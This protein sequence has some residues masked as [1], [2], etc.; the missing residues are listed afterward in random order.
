MKKVIITLI[1]TFSLLSLYSQNATI[2]G[3]VED[4]KTGERLIGANVFDAS[5]TK[6]G[7]ATNNYGFF[8]ITMPKGKHK[9]TASEI[10]Y[11]FWQKE[12][13]LIHDTTIT[14]QISSDIK[15]Q[16]VVISAKHNQVE[17]SQMSRIDIP[18]QTI[19]TLP[20]LFGEVDV[21]KILQLLPGVQ[22]GT[23]GTSGI[24]VRGGGPD[25]NLILL[26]G[27]PV[28]NA[29]HLFGFFSVFNADAI[30]NVRLYK[31]GFPARYGG[32][33]SSVIDINLK[34][35][36]MKKLTGNVSI[37]LIS[38]KF[39]IEG[40]I[41]KDKTSFIISAR[42]TY[43]D[44]ITI[45]LL[46]IAQKIGNKQET[47][48]KTNFIAGYY[49]YDFNAKINHKISEKDRL[50]L[51]IYGGQDKAYTKISEKSSLYESNGNM[52]LE[53]GNIISALRW[54]HVLSPKLFANLTL[55]YS[56]FN[57]L[58]QI[59]E[60]ETT[61]DDFNNK[62][63]ISFGLKYDSGIYDWA[64]KLD[65]DYN[66]NNNNKIKYGAT[67]IYHTFHPGG[68]KLFYHS[69][70]FNLDSTIG[71]NP[72]KALEYAAYAEDNIRIGNKIKINIGGRLSAFKVRDTLYLSPEPRISGRLLL[73]DN[74]SIKLSYAKMKQYLHFLT[75]NTVGMPTDLWL[76]AT[77]KVVPQKSI[78]YAAGTSIALN[79]KITLVF[80]T[81]YKEMYNLIE[82]KEGESIFGN[83]NSSS[84]ANQTWETKV[85][86]GRG[87][88][89][90][91][92]LLIKK[93]IGKLT[94][95][96]AY[97]LAWS[98][99]KFA[100]ISFGQLFPYRYDRRHDLSIVGVYKL[101]D[102]WNFGLTFVYGSG[103][104]ITLSQINFIPIN[105]IFIS[106]DYSDKTVNFYGQRNNYR[107][108]AYNRLD[109]SA[110]WSKQIK[111]GKRTW[112]F[113]VYNVYNHLNPFFV[114]VE[115]YNEDNK[116]KLV[117]YSIFPIMPSISYKLEF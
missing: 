26:D 28:Y 6:Y 15:L 51:S 32:R 5:N 95:W 38:S 10:G 20:A 69:D 79:N 81:F 105:N 98:N 116:P 85:T 54:N 29:N 99:R 57:F 33:L 12:I 62:N 35:G 27:V 87:W 110:N 47:N 37:G 63:A 8:S 103:N 43:I 77:D 73:T 11:G 60:D 48:N 1:L 9:I 56:R 80:E 14:I 96:I 107:L 112:S 66:L 68:T 72:L 101:N 113:G 22:S 91:G 78:Q 88:A 102:N 75:N 42:R 117:I 2:S 82:L 4:A 58:T 100:D 50:Y 52:K 49:F 108:P 44:I 94:G 93:D 90:G 31:G 106:D 19:K 70:M 92:E 21:M 55:T 64:G 7:T 17:S 89:Y 65:F 71:D 83:F 115:K 109:L 25:Q 16:Q 13:N 24:Y 53:W 36:N 76:P 18:V 86:Q 114:D 3:Y 67:A 30:S 104:P 61:Y 111:L 40:P 41:K 59:Y 23:E 34:E 39:T 45:P 46:K 74:W 97:T 84:S